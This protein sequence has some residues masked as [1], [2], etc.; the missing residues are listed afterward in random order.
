MTRSISIALLVALSTGIQVEAQQ[1]SRVRTAVGYRQVQPPVAVGH[2]YY[3]PVIPAV[4]PS[5]VASMVS[6]V[7]AVVDWPEQPQLPELSQ[8]QQE[9]AD[10]L[11]RQAREELNKSN[12][13]RASELFERLI[14]RHEGYR[15]TPDAYY[16]RAFALSKIKSSNDLEEALELLQ[17]QRRR[18]PRAPTR[19]QA[20]QLLIAIRSQLA[21]RGD[22]EAAAQV[23]TQADRVLRQQQC[24][25]NQDED[26][27]DA[28]LQA[29]LNMD[30]ASAMPI[31]RSI[32]QKKD[33][34]S[35]PLRRKAVFHIANKRSAETEDM[36]LD[37]ARNDPDSEV[38]EQ[39]VFWLS[40][41]G[42][43]KALTAIEQ[44]LNTST[45]RDVQERAIFALSQHRSPRA[46][47]VLRA[48]ATSN[49]RPMS[50]R[51]KAIFQ[52]S[53][54]RDPENGRFLRDLYS[55]LNE[56][57]LKEQ[58]I[59]ALSQRRGEG[60]E[61]WLMDVALNTNE[62]VEMRKKALFHAGQTRSVSITDLVALYDRMNSTDMKDQLIFVY[63]QRRDEAAVDKLID[64]AR[65][66]KD[67]ELRKK[68]IFWLGQSK[69]PKA[70]RA[71][72]E[73]IG[74]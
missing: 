22:S 15:Y 37:A 21:Q 32:M 27:R 63:S 46:G 54:H 2:T 8:D 5:A 28:A 44:I 62:D 64:I 41:V 33:A 17:E 45:S 73:I 30:A 68:A 60:N 58:V 74:N 1:R 18:Y 52:L 13:R 56:D 16:W 48:W 59:F 9:A 20:E 34:C 42:T 14:E 72:Q 43:E 66:E 36:L 24:P 26:I 7:P 67:R 47:A 10:N 25:A 39:G 6:V 38:R 49:E 53:Q 51:E 31:L 40:Q 50:L 65:N 19:G 71:I 70:L 4:P 57:R 61:R 69:H 11:Y 3:V 55:K 12:Y 23:A 29:L 35:A